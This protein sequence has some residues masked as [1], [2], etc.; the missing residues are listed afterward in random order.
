MLDIK[1]L[2]ENP[3][4][5]RES[6]KKRGE[7]TQVVDLI[8]EKDKSWREALQKLEQMRSTRNKVSLENTWICNTSV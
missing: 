8:L 2:R 3:N 1:L 6:Q 7:S 4:L 5:L